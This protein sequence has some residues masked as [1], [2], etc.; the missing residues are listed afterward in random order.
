MQLKK[1]NIKNALFAASYAL[2]AG[3]SVAN[4]WDFDSAIMYYGEP[5]RVQALEGIFSAK[6]TLKNDREFS[7]KLVIDSLTGASANGAVPQASPQ[8]FTTPSGNGQYSAGASETPL[9]DTFLDT[10][11]QLA[12]QWSQ[13]LGENY[14]VSTGTNFS[15]EYDYQSFAFNGV[16]GRYFNDKNT[17]VSLGI[18]YS[19][20]TIDAVGGRPVGLST[21]VVDTGQFA[22]DEAFRAAFNATRQTGGEDGKDT[23]DVILGLTQV[24]NRRWLTQFNLSLSEIDGY[25]SDPYKVVSRVDNSGTAI[26]QLYE[27]RPDTR[28]KQALFAQ[29]KYHFENSVWDISYRLTNDDWGIQSHTIESR[30][31]FLF[32]NNSYL[33]PHI[34]VY[35][36]SE[37]DFY[38][39]FLRDGE[40]LPEFASADYRIGKLNT[41]TFGVKYGKKL[42]S[43][44]E[45][46]VRI[47]YYNQAPQDPGVAA[48]GQ[49]SSLELYPSLDAVIVQFNYSF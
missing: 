42:N 29:S 47:E 39:P 17:T 49:L 16:L 6:K 30:Y 18:S 32:A 23:A 14:L 22:N 3:N 24:I 27:N 19:L 10:R 11:V 41:Y 31:R 43:G 21:M 48:P 37:A 1:R 20:D 28:S 46:G 2:L 4:D 7:T 33:E 35:Q 12:A 40:V 15:N 45:Y 36:Q 25:L 44:R 38:S 8:T 34:R 5:D 26:D 13:P 9:D